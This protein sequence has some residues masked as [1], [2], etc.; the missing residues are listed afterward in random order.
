M[1]ALLRNLFAGNLGNLF[2]GT[3]PDCLGTCSWEPLRINGHLFLATLLWGPCLGALLWDLAWAPWKP[4][5]GT[6]R[7]C[8]WEPCLGTCSWEP[9]G[10]LLVNLAREP[11]SG[12]LLG[13]LAW[14][15][16]EPW[17]PVPGNLGALEISAAPTCSKP[18]LWLK[19]PSLRGW[20]K[21]IGHGELSFFGGFRGCGLKLL[22]FSREE[23]L[24]RLI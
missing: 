9:L 20:G 21:N 4:C 10:T 14:E 5:L 8:S 12:T 6:C 13:N 19:T 22:S 2:L 3:L 18:C 23:G 17:E 15:P 24:H 7:N 16:W 1:G 11:C